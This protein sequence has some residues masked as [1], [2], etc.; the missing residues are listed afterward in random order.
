MAMEGHFL[1]ENPRSSL[2]FDYM[3]ELWSLMKDMGRKVP[4]HSEQRFEVRF[5]YHGGI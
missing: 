3:L 5:F 2:M 4:C 1:L